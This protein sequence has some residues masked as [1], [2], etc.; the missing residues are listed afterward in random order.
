MFILI[1]F[2]WKDFFSSSSSFSFFMKDRNSFAYILLWYFTL[3]YSISI[4]LTLFCILSISFLSLSFSFLISLLF[5][6]IK[7]LFLFCSSFRFISI[8]PNCPF[9]IQVK[10]FVLSSIFLHILSLFS[11]NNSNWYFALISYSFINDK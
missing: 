9:N 8:S 3:L 2:I 4:F 10:S 5:F 7:L 11:L 6:S 1:N